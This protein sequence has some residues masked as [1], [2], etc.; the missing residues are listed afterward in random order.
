MTVDASFLES[1]LARQ[2]AHVSCGEAKRP[3]LGDVDAFYGANAYWAEVETA[4]AQAQESNAITCD[5]RASSASLRGDE[6]LAV[7][8]RADAAAYRAA[9]A[10]HR[11][12]S[13]AFRTRAGLLAV[14]DHAS[15][16][17]RRRK[18]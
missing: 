5:E 13:K 10:V 9:A 12:A 1:I 4:R 8:A 11:A 6:P 14:T 18:E 17:P 2:M 15:S 7:H 3:E 16:T